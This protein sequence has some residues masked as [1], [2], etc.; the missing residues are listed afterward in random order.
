MASAGSGGCGTRSAAGWAVAGGGGGGRWRRLVEWGGLQQSVSA[1][2]HPHITHMSTPPFSPLLLSHSFSLLSRVLVSSACSGWLLSL[3]VCACRP[4]HETQGRDADRMRIRRCQPTPALTRVAN[5]WTALD[6][7]HS[8]SSTRRR[9][10]YHLPT[11]HRQRPVVVSL[12][13][14]ETASRI[15]RRRC[16]SLSPHCTIAHSNC[17]AGHTL[18]TQL[19][20][21]HIH[22]TR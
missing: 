21:T 3:T 10:S 6:C 22:I 11:L 19:G 9:R 2:S 5:H 8:N 18:P 12:R 20:Q 1:C 14:S 4:N 17:T 7:T 15:R 13:R 16:L